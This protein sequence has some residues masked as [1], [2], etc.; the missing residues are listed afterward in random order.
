[1]PPVRFTRTLLALSALSFSLAQA[2]FAEDGAT[3]LGIYRAALNNE[4]QLAA[5]RHQYQAAREQIPQARAHLLPTLSASGSKEN[6]WLSRNAAAGS[7]RAVAI[8]NGRQEI[9]DSGAGGKTRQDG[10][11][12]V[13]QAQLSQ[14]LFHLD[15]WYQLKAAKASVDSAAADLAAQEQQL[16][17]NSAKAY[18]QALQ[19]Q[20]ELSAKKA[21]EQSLKRQWDQAQ[22]RLKDGVSSITDVLDAQAAYDVARAERKGDER[23]LDDAFEAIARLTGEPISKID[24]LRH[25]LPV[26]PPEPFDIQ[27]WS[28]RAIAQS[29]HL[30]A[31]ALAVTSA[32]KQVTQRK[33]GHLPTLD[34]TASYGNYDNDAYGYMNP[35]DDGSDPWSGRVSR[36]SIAV[37]LNVPLYSGGSVSSQVRE[38]IA[39][40][41]ESRDKWEDARREV[42]EQTRNAFRA[43]DSDIDQIKARL[44]TIKSSA[45]SLK[46]NRVGA[47][48]GIRNTADILNA[49]KQLY[50]A[51]RDYNNARYDFII[52]TLTLKQA[53]GT[54]SPADL[55]SLAAYAKPDYDPK[56]DFLPP[57]IATVKDS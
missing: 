31:A 51:V 8:I 17:F 15:A 56:K 1:M 54:L 50:S 27:A 33:A 57:D 49:Q 18:F 44:Q 12:T 23:K 34:L 40:L 3:L 6:I 4:P 26:L 16:M 48:L 32:E 21:E 52:N 30:N 55:Q 24:G 13:W 25:N 14:P 46:A 39:R 22:A 9:V 42:L 35:Q 38:S 28:Q 41:G 45:E 37:Q 20:D 43:I 47:D 53:V 19:A 7:G 2:A 5:A 29:P 36:K 11:G 10:G